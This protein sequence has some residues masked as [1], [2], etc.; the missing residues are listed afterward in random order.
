MRSHLYRSRALQIRAIRDVPARKVLAMLKTASLLVTAAIGSKAVQVWEQM[1]CCHFSFALSA[2]ALPWTWMGCHCLA[3][4]L[5]VFALQEA[6]MLYCGEEIGT[7][8]DPKV[9]L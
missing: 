5:F 4:A 8:A 7:G 3:A 2:S 9:S 6:P 1:A